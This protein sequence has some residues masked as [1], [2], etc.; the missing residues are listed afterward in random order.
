MFFALLSAGIGSFFKKGFRLKDT[1]ILADEGFL[2]I[3]R[4]AVGRNRPLL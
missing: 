2:Q 1:K 4:R 3:C